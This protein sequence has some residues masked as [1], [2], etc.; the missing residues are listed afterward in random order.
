MA[1]LLGFG[2]VTLPE[3]LL[4]PPASVQQCARRFSRRL[5]NALN[6]CSHPMRKLNI[7]GPQTVTILSAPLTPLNTNFSFYRLPLLNS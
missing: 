6:K 7:Q 2:L 5:T 3:M 1:L 4:Q